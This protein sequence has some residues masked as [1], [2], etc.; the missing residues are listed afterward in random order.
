MVYGVLRAL[1]GDP[2]CLTPSLADNSVSL[3]PAIEASGPHDLAVRFRAVRQKRISVHRIP[4][5]VRDDRETPLVKE[6]DGMG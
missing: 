3:T 1:P 6:R 4:L 2:A 5:H